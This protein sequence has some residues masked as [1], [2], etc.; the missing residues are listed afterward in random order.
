MDRRMF[1]VALALPLR[2]AQAGYMRLS[3]V[4][5]KMGAH[6]SLPNRFDWRWASSRQII[7]HLDKTHGHE[8]SELAGHSRDQLLQLHDVHHEGGTSGPYTIP[9]PN[10]RIYES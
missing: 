9:K 8:P 1:L 5:V 7:A 6:W 4:C 10:G 2:V 3:E